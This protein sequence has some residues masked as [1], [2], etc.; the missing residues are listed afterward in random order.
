M[1]SAWTVVEGGDTSEEGDATYVDLGTAPAG[2]ETTFTYAVEAPTG[3]TASGEYRFGPVEASVD[4]D[5]WETVAG[6]GDTDYVVGVETTVL[7]TR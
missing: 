4:G 3:P 1:P 5:S 7:G 2:Q 6:T